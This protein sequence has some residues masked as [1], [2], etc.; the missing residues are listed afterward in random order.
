[1]VHNNWST[2]VNWLWFPHRKGTW[3]LKPHTVYTQPDSTAERRCTTQRGDHSHRP[4]CLPVCQAPSTLFFICCLDSCGPCSTAAL[5]RWLRLPPGLPP[6]LPASSQVGADLQHERAQPPSQK[7][8][9]YGRVGH[10]TSKQFDEARIPHVD[11]EMFWSCGL[12]RIMKFYLFTGE[13]MLENAW[14]G[15]N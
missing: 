11:Q 14:Q 10:M 8:H 1:M 7:P 6:G 3:T 5:P 15:R 9:L 2:T 4:A 13:C 12:D